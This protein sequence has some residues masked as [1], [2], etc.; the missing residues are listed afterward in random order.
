MITILHLDL[1]H[2]NS[3]IV[4]FHC[5][6]GGSPCGPDGDAAGRQRRLPADPTEGAGAHPELHTN[7]PTDHLDECRQQR[8]R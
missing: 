6:S 4:V 2:D 8:P 3:F 7:I 1:H 5:F